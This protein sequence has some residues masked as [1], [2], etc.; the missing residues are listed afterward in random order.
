MAAIVLT[1]AVVAVLTLYASHPDRWLI[2]AGFVA[3]IALWYLL[4]P[5]V[6]AVLRWLR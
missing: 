4:I 3:A 6:R 2:A 5:V 1:A